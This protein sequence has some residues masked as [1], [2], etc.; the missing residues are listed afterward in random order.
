LT[1]QPTHAIFIPRRVIS[2]AKLRIVKI[3]EQR[4][5]ITKTGKL[6]Y[7]VQS[8]VNVMVEEDREYLVNVFTGFPVSE[9][10]EYEFLLNNMNIRLREPK[11]SVPGVPIPGVNPNSAKNPK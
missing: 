4:E 10:Q 8:S 1:N 9:G 11:I 2:M 6:L 3:F 5:I 7:V